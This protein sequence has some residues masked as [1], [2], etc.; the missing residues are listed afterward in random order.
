MQRHGL[1]LPSLFALGEVP[2]TIIIY[3]A[4]LM[5]LQTGI[6]PA[7]AAFLSACLFLPWGLRGLAK[8][9]VSGL[10]HYRRQTQLAELALVLALMAVALTFTNCTRREL[11]LFV[12]LFVLSLLTA[13][14]ELVARLYYECALPPRER[15]LWTGV[16][17]FFSQTAVVLTY[18]LVLILVG[19]LQ[20]FYRSISFAWA[21]G[22]YMVAGV[23][24]LFAVY[25][26]IFLAP[27]SSQ[28]LA[29]Q[30]DKPVSASRRL[31]RVVRES[32][33]RL[34]AVALFL[35]LLPQ[36]LMFFTR[37]IFLVTPASRGGLGCTIQDV[38]LAQGAVGVIAF[39]AG[40]MLGRRMLINCGARRVFWWLALALGLSP[41]VYALMVALPPASLWG[42]CAAT[43]TA[44]FLFGFG[45]PVCNSFLRHISG[46]RY[47]HTVDYLLNPL[48][49]LSMFVP[50]ALSGWLLSL[51]GFA[52]FFALDALMLP[53]ALLL[54]LALRVPSRLLA[55]RHRKE[56]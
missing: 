11:W 28:A 5:F 25:H 53:L 49:A 21:Q 14:H 8:G 16:A 47:R 41:C 2:A 13:W 33:R 9:F 54:L 10:G 29:S 45:V 30:S 6:A 1:W 36:S 44:Q 24:L 15:R 40:L 42:L 43:F 37:V 22:C 3:I 34:A 50:M 52:F 32:R 26:I 31:L 51:L 39:S 12:A 20:V 27:A 19:A 35:L 46:G 4:L 23:C 48:V 7:L 18:G 38:A 55:G 56:K 17:M